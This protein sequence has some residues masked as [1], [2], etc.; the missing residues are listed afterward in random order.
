MPL[1]RRELVKIGRGRTCIQGD[2]LRVPSS[3]PRVAMARTERRFS[4]VEG[5]LPFPPSRRADLPS[6]PP[7]ALLRHTNVIVA[8]GRRVGGRCRISRGDALEGVL[9]GP[10]RVDALEATCRVRIG[11]VA[12]LA[13]ACERALGPCGGGRKAVVPKQRGRQNSQGLLFEWA[14]S[15]ECFSSHPLHNHLANYRLDGLQQSSTL[16][17]WRRRGEGKREYSQRKTGHDI[18]D[19]RQPIHAT[20]NSTNRAWGRDGGS[21]DREDVVAGDALDERVEI[22]SGSAREAVRVVVGPGRPTR[23]TDRTGY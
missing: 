3:R 22:V 6:P 19:V 10:A 9:R 16:H 18:T 11:R 15:F 12:R 2:T 20:S 23:A 8:R 17:A 4:N 5:M 7:P 1:P 21:T 14:V 13:K